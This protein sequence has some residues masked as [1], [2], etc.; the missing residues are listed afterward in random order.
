MKHIFLILL[1]TYYR[2]A[3]YCIDENNPK[4]KVGNG[5]TLG[6]FIQIKDPGSVTG[7]IDNY[8]QTSCNGL[9]LHEYGHT[10]QSRHYG[11]AYLFNI[12]IPSLFDAKNHRKVPHRERWFER[13]A[14]AYGRDYFGNYWTT[15]SIYPTYGF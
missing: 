7:N 3:T 1:C 12:G 8:I 2:G 9:Y 13:E 15:Y 10:I 4:M 5:M 6:N 14:S 11:L